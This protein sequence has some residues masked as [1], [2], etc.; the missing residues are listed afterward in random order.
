MIPQPLHPAVVHF[1][2]VLVVLL[3]IAALCALLLI[4]R[5]EEAR[6]MWVPVTV[7]ALALAGSAWIAVETGEEEEDA[8]EEVVAESAIHEH[9]EAAE[10][11]LPLS[12]G[13]FLLVGAG[14][15]RGEPGRIA[16]HVGT[17]A[18]FGLVAVG[19]N[20]GHT[21]G[22]LVYEH[23]AASAYTSVDRRS[24]PDSNSQR[25]RDERAESD[26]ERDRH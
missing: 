4:R 2:I 1:P 21:G 13:V 16:R 14:L 11:F 15:L 17:V 25:D 20:V 7:L 23:G 3:P 6:K 19:V 18:A 12:A 8:V 5:G 26:R 24:Q 10:L 22:E 9:E